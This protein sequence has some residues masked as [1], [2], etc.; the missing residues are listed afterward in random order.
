MKWKAFE[1]SAN[2]APLILPLSKHFRHFSVITRIECY[3]LKP[4]RNPYCH[5]ESI[6]LKYLYTRFTRSFFLKTGITSEY[7]NSERKVASN[8]ELLKL[9]KINSEKMS[10]L[11]L[12]VFTGIL[13][14]WQTFLLFRLW[15]SAKILFCVSKLN[16]NCRS[17]MILD[18]LGW[19]SY[20]LIALKQNRH[21]LSLLHCW[22]EFCLYLNL[23]QFGWNIY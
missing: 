17:W 16:E 10:M 5:F 11:S 3:V 8:I 13:L 1:R 22:P 14:S 9:W 18:N 20:F 19:T 23:Q 21:C 6:W 12:V 4:L 7:I 15:I 2:I